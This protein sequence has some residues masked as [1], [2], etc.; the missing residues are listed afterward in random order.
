MESCCLIRFLETC[1]SLQVLWSKSNKSS[2]LKS[3]QTSGEASRPATRSDTGQTQSSQ[4]RHQLLTIVREKKCQN[5]VWIIEQ[6]K[7]NNKSSSQH[8]FWP[9]T[10]WR[11]YDERREENNVRTESFVSPFSRQFSSSQHGSFV[12]KIFHRNFMFSN[13]I[14]CSKL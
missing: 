2:R 6:S 14:I 7:A 9:W 13:E 12:E 10:E 5:R 1:F 11:Y 4:H 3:F 8:S